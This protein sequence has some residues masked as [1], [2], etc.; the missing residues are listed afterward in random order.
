MDE[1]LIQQEYFI[2][3]EA[4][5]KGAYYADQMREARKSGRIGKVPY[6]ESLQVY[7]HWDLG[8]N[9]TTAIWF[10]QAIQ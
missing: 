3:F 6:D 1:D 8:I 5:V 10:W 9:D 2:S 7:T 4:S